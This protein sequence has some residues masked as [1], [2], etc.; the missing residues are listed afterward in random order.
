MG[1]VFAQA[2]GSDFTEISRRLMNQIRAEDV[3]LL[4]CWVHASVA[5]VLHDDFILKLFI[6]RA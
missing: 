6:N 2:Y 5:S 4:Y 3:R 1:G